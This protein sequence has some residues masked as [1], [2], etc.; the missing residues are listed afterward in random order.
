MK[1]AKNFIKD[2]VLKYMYGLLAKN[3]FLALKYNG[4]L[5]KLPVGRI[6]QKGLE[7]V[8]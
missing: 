6:M 1:V 4:L 2:T 7:S 8:F 5:R 3:T